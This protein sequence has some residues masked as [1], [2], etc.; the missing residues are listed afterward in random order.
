MRQATHIA[1]RLWAEGRIPRTASSFCSPEILSDGY[2]VTELRFSQSHCITFKSTLTAPAYIH[3]QGYPVR[4]NILHY[5]K[6]SFI[7]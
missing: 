6:T 7:R 4:I 1:A 5:R 2:T 3:V